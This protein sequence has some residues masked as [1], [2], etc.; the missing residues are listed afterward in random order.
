[1]SKIIKALDAHLAQIEGT[2]NSPTKLKT[3]ASKGVTWVKPKEIAADKKEEKKDEED[4]P[5]TE[6]REDKHMV[7]LRSS[8]YKKAVQ[9][10]KQLGIPEQA[11]ELRI[12]VILGIAAQLARGDGLQA[13]QAVKAIKNLLVSFL[14]RGQEKLDK[15]Q[16]YQNFLT[17][18][19]LFASFE[20]ALGP[21]KKTIPLSSEVKQ[22]QALAKKIRAGVYG[23]IKVIANKDGSYTAVCGAWILARKFK[24][25][26][27]KEINSDAPQDMMNEAL[28]ELKKVK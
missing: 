25:G 9:M 11:G 23:P 6:E 19:K 27:I 18:H 8:H 21:A 13:L 1:M 3:T 7:S 12:M 10:L 22:I 28:A 2:K 14:S 17:D 26:T 4:D 16:S 15:N 24:D 20:D 5:T